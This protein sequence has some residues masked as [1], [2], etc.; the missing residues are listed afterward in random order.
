MRLR[1]FLP[2]LGGLVAC[3]GTV[4]T[5]EVVVELEGPS[6]EHT[7]SE[8]VLVA[9]GELRLDVMASD[10]EGVRAV[11]VYHRTE[12]STYWESSSLTS[13][14]EAWFVDL[15]DLEEPGLEYYFKATDDGEEPATSYLPES[16]TAA[17]YQREVFALASPLPWTEECSAG[18]I[19]RACIRGTHARTPRPA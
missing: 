17:P 13:D 15:V 6:L 18:G 16:A 7:P 1:A 11:T 10:P 3:Q 12:G 2:L 5:G 19:P 4:D 14:G 8:D 9:G